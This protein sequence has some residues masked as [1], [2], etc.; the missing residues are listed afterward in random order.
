MH[1]QISIYHA[2]LGKELLVHETFLHQPTVAITR[3]NKYAIMLNC[4]TIFLSFS[5]KI[6]DKYRFIFLYLQQTEKLQTNGPKSSLPVC[7][8][9]ITVSGLILIS[10]DDFK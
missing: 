10:I 8:R 2:I 1:F 7:L 5:M 6:I 9:W 4:Y 3:K